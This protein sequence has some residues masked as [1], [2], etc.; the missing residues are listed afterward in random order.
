MDDKYNLLHFLLTTNVFYFTT[1]YS[2]LL[3]CD[4]SADVTNL[5]NP[6]QFI[7]ACVNIQFLCFIGDVGTKVKCKNSFENQ[8]VSPS[9]IINFNWFSPLREGSTESQ[10]KQNKQNKHKKRFPDN[11]IEFNSIIFF[12]KEN[13]GMLQ[14]VE[15]VLSNI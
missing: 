7:T 2:V 12:D 4:F 1:K 8:L 10:N 14:S 5:Y 6:T 13:K 11:K 9:D 15:I 3:S